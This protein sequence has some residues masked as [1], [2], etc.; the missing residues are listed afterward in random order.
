MLVGAY[1]ITTTDLIRLLEFVFK[2]VVCFF[3]LFFGGGGRGRDGR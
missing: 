3:L 2:V 1:G